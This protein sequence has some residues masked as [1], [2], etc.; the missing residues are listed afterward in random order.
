M[1]SSEQPRDSADS[2]KPKDKSEDLSA[3]RTRTHQKVSEARIW[4]LPTT[5]GDWWAVGE[6]DLLALAESLRTSA[7]EILSAK[8]NPDEGPE[9]ARC[10]RDHIIKKITERLHDSFFSFFSRTLLAGGWL[11]I[12]LIGLKVPGWLKLLDELLLL[13]GAGFLFYTFFRYGP[14]VARWYNLRIEAQHAFTTRSKWV[15]NT[16]ADRLAGALLLRTRLPQNDRGQSPDDELLDTNAYRNLIRD[17][18]TSVE[19]LSTLG[20]ALEHEMILHDNEGNLRKMSDV[21]RD[22]GLDVETAI[23][24]RDLASA[25]AEIALDSLSD[26]LSP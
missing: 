20:K 7:P 6:R 25:A 24:Y 19:E 9:V 17:G 10:G 14:S 21:A 8:F 4:V 11:L 1:S 2:R 13:L 12:A 26:G 15:Q 22:L 5:N 16:L 23:F 18:V 3:P